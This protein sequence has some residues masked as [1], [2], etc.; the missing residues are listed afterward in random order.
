MLP[1]RHP[2]NQESRWLALLKP[3]LSKRTYLLGELYTGQDF[4]SAEA[5][6][7]RGCVMINPAIEIFKPMTFG[8]EV[9]FDGSRT[10]FEGSRKKRHFNKEEMV[11]HSKLPSVNMQ[12]LQ[13]TSTGQET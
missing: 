11:G 9:K 12:W 13:G 7:A 1:R 6:M 8:R 5:V 10:D 4:E 3:Y 2:S